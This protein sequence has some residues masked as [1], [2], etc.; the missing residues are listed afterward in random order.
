PW[1]IMWAIWGKQRER[2]SLEELKHLNDVLQKHA[3]IS[4][5]NKD[6]VVE[7]LRSIAELM[8]WGD[9]HEP[10]FF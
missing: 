3:I 2:F 10:A 8:I 5:A 7:T 4:D 6:T 1:C 9:Q